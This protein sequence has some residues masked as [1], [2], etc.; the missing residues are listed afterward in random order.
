MAD[1]K[2]LG[3]RPPDSSR[4]RVKASV[5]KSSAYPTRM[6]SVG[7]DFIARERNG[8]EMTERFH[9]LSA[10]GPF[11][12]SGHGGRSRHPGATDLIALSAVSFLSLFYFV[13]D[14]VDFQAAALFFSRSHDD[15]VGKSK[16]PREPRR[17]DRFRPRRNMGEHDIL[18][19]PLLCNKSCRLLRWRLKR[20]KISLHRWSSLPDLFDDSLRT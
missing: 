20:P 5:V 18:S 14:L 13:L 8:T 12:C 16:F 1:G 17:S 9:G 19:H 3:A 7:R 6:K 4:E 10:A 15:E 11:D 2:T